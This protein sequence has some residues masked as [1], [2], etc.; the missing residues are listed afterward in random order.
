MEVVL[1]HRLRTAPS[2]PLPI[3]HLSLS[4]S[5]ELRAIGEFRSIAVSRPVRERQE[6]ERDLEGQR[7][8]LHK[9]AEV[10]EIGAP[11]GVAPKPNMNTTLCGPG[12]P[13]VAMHAGRTRFTDLA[14]SI[15]RPK[16]PR[17][18]PVPGIVAKP[19]I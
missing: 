6:T 9:K 17:N 14:N 4:N 13:Y 8:Y 16:L 19:P 12:G 5:F 10:M 18:A 11:G 15:I 7:S 1:R 3:D 2:R